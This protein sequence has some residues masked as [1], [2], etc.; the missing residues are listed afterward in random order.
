MVSWGCLVAAPRQQRHGGAAAAPPSA[1]T[2]A[3]RCAEQ[4]TC[5]SGFAD[6]G[7]R[8]GEDEGGSN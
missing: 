4:L 2:A 6:V 8:G 3:C 1:A 7:G 5:D